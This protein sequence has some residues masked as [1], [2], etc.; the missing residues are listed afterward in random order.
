MEGGREPKM[1]IPAECFHLRWHMPR[2]LIAVTIIVVVLATPFRPVYAAPRARLSIAAGPAGAE[3]LPLGEGLARLIARSLPD[4]EASAETTP[5]FVD[6]ALRIGEKRADLA[7]L[8]SS[9][10]LQASRGEG[11]FQGKTIP[12]RTL[13]PLFSVFVHLVTLEGTGINSITDLRGKRVS[14][15]PPGS[16]F[17]VAA[18]AVLKATG[19][20]AD[21]DIR[22]ESLSVSEAAPALREKKIDAFF[23]LGFL[24]GSVVLELA[25]TPGV[26]IKLIPLD[27]VLPTLQREEGNIY[28]K[29]IIPKE[30]YPGLPADVPTIGEIDLLVVHQDFDD[31]LVYQITKLVFEKRAE[32][33]QAHKQ[34]QYITLLGAARRSPIPF[35][36]GAIRYFKE[37]GVEGF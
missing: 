27:S 34:A 7:F 11:A 12:V 5:G 15:G 31:N 22:A 36:P 37:R 18:L 2:T 6:A 26:R 9:I 16:G 3:L 28:F 19:I 1:E 4:V 24:P 35:H 14:I 33:A 29:V 10:A 8:T 32:L 17:R 20:D 25:T 13:A 21:R 23:W 30:F